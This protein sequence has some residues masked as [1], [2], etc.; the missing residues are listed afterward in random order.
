MSKDFM[1]AQINVAREANA[2]CAYKKLVAELAARIA[3]GIYAYPH[4][5]NLAGSIERFSVNKAREIIALATLAEP[6]AHGDGVE[7]A[8]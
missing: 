4:D 5:W 2:H 6:Y 1:L 7:D 3:A 8:E